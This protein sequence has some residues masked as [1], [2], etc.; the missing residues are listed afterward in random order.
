MREENALADA[1]SRLRIPPADVSRLLQVQHST[2]Q[3]AQHARTQADTQTNMHS[4]EGGPC[5]GWQR[6]H[7]YL[8]FSK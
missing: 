6:T 3:H 2:A 1:F 7:G 8:K 4:S 5:T